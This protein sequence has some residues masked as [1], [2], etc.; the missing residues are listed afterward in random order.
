MEPWD[1]K[2]AFSIEHSVVGLGIAI[3]QMRELAADRVG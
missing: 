2:T 3:E 1:K